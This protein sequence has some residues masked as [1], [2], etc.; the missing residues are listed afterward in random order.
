MERKGITQTLSDKSP[1]SLPF[2]TKAV[3]S[4]QSMLTLIALLTLLIA[5]QC[6][7]ANPP[8]VL[9]T[10]EPPTPTPNL[11]PPVQPGDGTDL[12]D[13][14]L[15][16]GIIRIGVRV[17]PEAEFSPPAFRGVSNA[18]TGGALN[19]F[20]IDIARQI[21][22]NLGLELE[23]VEAYPPVI[24]SGDW[25][26]EWD[27]ALASLVPFD[28]P[29]EDTPRQTITYSSPYAY[30]PMGILIP[31]AE[32]GIQTF[33]QLSNR[34]VGVL[35]YSAHQR[36]LTPEESPLTVQGQALIPQSQT[37]LQIVVLSNLQRAI[38]DLGQ[39]QS[40][41]SLQPDALFGPIPMFEE[42]IRNNLPVKLATEEKIIGI[43]P[44]AIAAVPQDG[45][46]VE[47]LL[48]EINTILDRLQR[49]GTL[50]EIYIRWYGQDLSHP[51]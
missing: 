26:G 29:P 12:I 4:W 36:L 11:I 23:L 8:N 24:I 37:D 25:Q 42:A 35:E 9:S 6:Q 34:R 3:S 38:R 10:L 21:A 13:R 41:D 1:D 16:T 45:L 39:P 40:E 43:Q 14:L 19:G 17:W 50:A 30:M 22:Q 31:A 5:P 18:A 28:Q 33:A 2:R 15:E 47:R 27:I 51:P 44:L 48:S 7:P 49:Q 32:D 46:K 20:E